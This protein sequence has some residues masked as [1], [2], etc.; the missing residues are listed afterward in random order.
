[1]ELTSTRAVIGG[2]RSSSSLAKVIFLSNTRHFGFCVLHLNLSSQ[3][4][5][6]RLCL[7]GFGGS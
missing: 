7:A 6:F 5:C 1:M 2:P 4:S 3:T